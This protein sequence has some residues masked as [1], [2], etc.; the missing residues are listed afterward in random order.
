MLGQTLVWVG[1]FVQ[2]EAHLRRAIEIFGPNGMDY[3]LALAFQT[4]TSLELVRGDAPA[5]LAYGRQAATYLSKVGSPSDLVP[6]VDVCLGDALIR[7]GSPSE[8]LAL[9]ERARSEQ[10]KAAGGLDAKKVYAWDALRCEGAALTALGRS[11]EALPYLER[12]LT[13]KRRM[14]PADYARAELALARALTALR[15]DRPRAVQLAN[16]ARAELS[17]SPFLTWELKEVDA[18]LAAPPL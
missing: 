12:S 3:W 18:W 4:L 8:A 5:A 16:A 17:E 7:S 13:L 15:R 9:C 2:A 1:D 11:E 14:F 6:Y 10:E